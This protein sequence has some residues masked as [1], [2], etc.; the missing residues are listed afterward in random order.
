LVSMICSP[1]AVVTGVPAVSAMA[2]LKMRVGVEIAADAANMIF[3][4]VRREARIVLPC[5]AKTTV[6]SVRDAHSKVLISRLHLASLAGIAQ[7]PRARS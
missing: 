6:S 5:F 4:M 1:E 2:F 7:K 3:I